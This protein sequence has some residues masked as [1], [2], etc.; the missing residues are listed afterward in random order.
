VPISLIYQMV[1]NI[2]ETFN[3]VSRVLR[4]VTDRQQTNDIQTTD[5]R[6]M[7]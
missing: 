1:Q 2:A 7:P 6:P 4:S 3:P 5:V